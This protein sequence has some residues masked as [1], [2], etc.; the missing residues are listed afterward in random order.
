MDCSASLERSE[1][2][3]IRIKEKLKEKLIGNIMGKEEKAKVRRKDHWLWM[4][5]AIIMTM[6]S[7]VAGVRYYL[8]KTYSLKLITTLTVIALIFWVITFIAY[9]QEDEKT[10]GGKTP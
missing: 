4:V 8:W 1:D 10:T 3:A 6:A 9:H 7:L 2:D 5:W